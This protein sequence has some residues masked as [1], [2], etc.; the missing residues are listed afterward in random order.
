[1]VAI[2]KG[3]HP[4]NLMHLNTLQQFSAAKECNI[5]DVKTM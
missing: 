2:E 5:I 4:F 3:T 1:M